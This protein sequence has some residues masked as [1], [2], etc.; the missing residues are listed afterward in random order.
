MISKK[1]LLVMLCTIIFANIVLAEDF[2]PNV[3]VTLLNQDPD[4]VSQGDVVKVRFKIENS[5]GS[6]FS[7]VIAE[8]I[9]Q[10][11]FEIYSGPA[12]KSIGVLSASQA[13]TRAVIID[14][15]LKVSE[16]A[17]KGDNEIKL[18]LQL[19]KSSSLE[20]NFTIAVDTSDRPDLNPLIKSTTIQ[21]AGKRGTVTIEL[22]NADKGN[23]KFVQLFL[24]PAGDYELLSSS[25]YVYLGDIDSDDSDSEDFDIYVNADTKSP[26]KLPIKIEYQDVN[27]KQYSMESALEARLFTSSELGKYGI[28]KKSYTGIIIIL[29][30]LLLAGYI[31]WRKIRQKKK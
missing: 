27:G 13:G 29:V 10:Y 19:S 5:G 6:T 3:Q 18:R 15:R 20:Y 7:N 31:V 9:P 1:L 21:Q 12:S 11:P 22:A 14:Y 4:P 24:L 30:L 25:N 2:F 16:N 23:A 26:L 17:V 28:V 8:L